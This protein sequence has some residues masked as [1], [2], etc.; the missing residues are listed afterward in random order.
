MAHLALPERPGNEA[1]AHY[2]MLSPSFGD[3][4]A[5]PTLHY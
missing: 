4:G 3:I 2:D 5:V 1:V